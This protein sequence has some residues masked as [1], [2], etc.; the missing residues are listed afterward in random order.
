MGIVTLTAANVGAFWAK[1]DRNIEDLTQRY[2]Y[3]AATCAGRNRVEDVIHACVGNSWFAVQPQTARAYYVKFEL[4][5]AR[6][7]DEPV[8]C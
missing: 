7:G 4:C 8:H 2:K 5:S 1:S 6:A 3:A